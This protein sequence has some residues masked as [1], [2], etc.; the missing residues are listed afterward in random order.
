[1]R[2]AVFMAGH[3]TPAM[4]DEHG[5]YGDMAINLLKGDDSE[6]WIQ[7]PVCDGVFPQEEELREF[8]ASNALSACKGVCVIWISVEDNHCHDS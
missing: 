5:N 6:E 8:Q 2:F 7:F 1:M 3:T 4:E